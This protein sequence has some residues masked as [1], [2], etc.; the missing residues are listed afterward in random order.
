MLNIEKIL[1]EGI[2]IFSHPVC[3]QNNFFCGFTTRYG[4]SSRK[5]FNTLNLAYHVGDED[6]SVQ[7]NRQLIIERLLKPGP[8]YL[9]S[10]LQVHGNNVLYV[11]KYTGHKDGSI[12]LEADSLI[13]NKHNIPIMVLGA[14]C[15]LIIIVDIK[16]KAVG[17][18]HAGWK[19]TLNGILGKTL[20]EFKKHFG[21][22]PENILIFFGPS[23]RNCCYKVDSILIDRFREEFGRGD[24]YFKKDND[25]FLDIIK[26]NLIHLKY[27]GIQKDNVFDV[28][29]CTSCSNG[30][31]SYRRENNTGRQA[32]IAMIR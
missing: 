31:F 7:S 16:E 22:S 30:F 27:F 21:S 19:G 2:N 6:K 29:K 9:Y 1:V 4:G 5:P 20:L 24:Y 17:V 26:L 32:A 23:I 18:V 10:A 15:N 25:F 28:G 3:D 12:P 13:T 11:D 8:E 14:D